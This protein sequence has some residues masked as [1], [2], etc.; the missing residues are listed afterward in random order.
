MQ[1]TLSQNQ[2]PPWSQ[3]AIIAVCRM[4]LTAIRNVLSKLEPY[5]AK[6]YPEDK[7]TEHSVVITKAQGLELL[8]KRNY[9]FTDKISP[10]LGEMIPFL[11][12][13]LRLWLVRPFVGYLY[14]DVVSNFR[15][16]SPSFT[17][18]SLN[19]LYHWTNGYART[20]FKTV[21]RII[22]LGRCILYSFS[23]VNA[24]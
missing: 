2:E 14:L 22:L 15:S 23:A 7:Q 4:L 19:P 3:K 24:Q 16:L 12:Q 6:E 21:L 8:R 10:T 11:P 13:K 18:I 17:Y 20:L 5:S 9:I 1:R